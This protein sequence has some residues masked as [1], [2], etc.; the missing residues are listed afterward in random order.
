MKF[1]GGPRADSKIE[2]VL[3]MLLEHEKRH[4]FSQG[5][6]FLKD[7]KECIGRAGLVRLDFD[8]DS[9]YVELAYFL[10]P[11]YWSKG[12]ATEIGKC[13]IEYAFN[14]LKV[15]YVYATIDPENKASLRVSE[16]LGMTMEKKS[17]YATLNKEVYYYKIDKKAFLKTII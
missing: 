5:A 7:T 15:E 3:N 14:N 16:K 8:Y 12:Y 6:V 4:G 17:Q 13:L 1:F 2:S 10:L 11:A 9:P